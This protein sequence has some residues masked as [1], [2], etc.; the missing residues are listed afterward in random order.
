MVS[1]WRRSISRSRCG[2]SIVIVPPGR[3]TIRMPSTKS[4]RSGT[5]ART[6]LPTMRSA[7]SSSGSLPASSVPKNAATVGTPRS[8]ATSATFSAGSTPECRDPARR[9]AGGGTRRCSRA[10]ALGCRARAP[11]ARP[12]ALRSARRARP[13]STTPTTGRRSHRRSR[14]ETRT[15]RAGPAGTAGTRVRA[16]DRT[17]RSRSA[18]PAGGAGWRA[19]ACRGRRTP[20]RASRRTAGIVRVIGRSSSGEFLVL[21][22][23]GQRDVA[24]VLGLASAVPHDGPCERVVDAQPR[25]PTEQVARATRVEAQGRRFVRRVGID[26]GVPRQATVPAADEVV[27]DPRRR[28]ARRRRRGRSSTHPPTR[29]R[30]T[31]GHGQRRSP[32]GSR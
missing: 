21:G 30:P 17:A 16:T 4:C 32:T 7:L 19:A 14:R 18:A 31:G 8:C 25:L 12:R 28:V 13:R 15:P 23:L 1:Y 26:L 6:L 3:S 20:R 11:V 22:E 5:C 24:S 29:A 27:G 9:S 10:R 2:N